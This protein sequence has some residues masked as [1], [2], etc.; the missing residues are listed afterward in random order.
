MG[1][2]SSVP[3][4]GVVHNDMESRL[5]TAVEPVRVSTRDVGAE[6]VKQQRRLAAIAQGELMDSTPEKSI[7]RKTRLALP[8]AKQQDVHAP[9]V[10][11]SRPDWVRMSQLGETTKGRLIKNIESAAA[12]PHAATSGLE[13]RLASLGMEMRI[14]DGDGNCQF[15]SAAFNLFGAQSH[16][17]V[18]RKSAVAHMER[19]RDFFGIYFEAEAEFRRYLGEMARSRTWGDELTLR[20]IVEVYCCEA[21]VV[22]SEPANWYLHYT[23]ELQTVDPEVARAPKGGKLPPLRKQIFLS[24]ISPIHYN[25]V[26]ALR[27]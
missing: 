4:R 20:A 25:A 6:Q 17:A 15:R 11:S 23:P 18:V 14:M 9:W 8:S 13:A 19:H 10:A 24:Y 12:K 2:S 1:C 7:H 22:T 21:H 5:T 26:V 27:V 16:H 3:E